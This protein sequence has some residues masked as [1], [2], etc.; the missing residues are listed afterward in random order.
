MQRCH[1]VETVQDES[2]DTTCRGI[3]VESRYRAIRDITGP[4]DCEELVFSEIFY[5][6]AHAQDDNGMRYNEYS[7]PVEL[8]T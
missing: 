1:E 5:Y 6:V 4:I 7:L 3:H 2:S 8:S